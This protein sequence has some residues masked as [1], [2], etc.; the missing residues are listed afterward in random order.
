MNKRLLSGAGLIAV[1]CILLTAFTPGA[2]RKPVYLNTSY[3]FEERA[4]DLVSRMTPEE[5]QSLLG[6]SMAAVPRL[7]VN[8]YNVWGEALHGYASY[9]NPEGGPATSFPNSVAVGA[10]WDPD[11]VQREASAIADEARGFNYPVIN[12]LTYW[13]PVVE[14]MRDPRWGRTG[15]SYGEDPYL[16]AQ[17]AGGFIRGLLGD[18][19]KYLKAVPTGKHFFANNSEFN[20]H[21]SSSDMDS[22]DMREF[23]LAS[24]KKLIEKD[25][26][27]SIMTCYN[28]VNGIP[29]T[30]NKFLVDTIARKTY[31]MKGYVTGDC[32]AVSDI[33]SGHFY[34]KTGPEAAAMGL[35][36]GVDTDCGSVYQTSALDALKLGLISEA[37]IDLALVNMF[38][39]RMRIGEFDPKAKVTYAHIGKE[40]I[41]SPGHVALAEEVAIKTPVLLKNNTVS[42]T[43][44]KALPLK[45]G[46][47]KKIAVL[48]PQADKV[49]LGPYSGQTLPENMITPLSGI[50]DFLKS[51]N[52]T[53]EIVHSAGA[54]TLSSSNLFNIFWFELVKNDGKTV[55]FDANKFTAS[56]K[57]IISSAGMT[58]EKSVKNIRDGGWTSYKDIDV[59]GVAKFNIG[60]TV[61]G[62]GGIIEVRLDSENGRVLAVVEAKAGQGMTSAFMTRTLTGENRIPEASGKQNLFLVYHSPA[63]SRA[64]ADRKAIEMAASADVALVFVGTDD[65]TANE[66][67]DRLDLLLPGNQYELIKAVAEVNPYTVVVMQTLGM[68]EVEQF[69]N[70]PNVAGIIWTGFNGQ[71]QGRAIA[72]ILFGDVNPGG[73]LNA[74]WF[75]SLNDIPEITDYTLRGGP[76]KNGRTYWYFSKDVSYEFGYGL[77]YTTF[78]YGNFGIDKRSI[79][80]NDKIKISVDVTNSGDFDGDEVVQVYVKTPDSPASLQRPAKRLKGFQRIAIPAGQTRTVTIGIDCA[81]LWFWDPLNKKIT[82]DQGRYIFEIGSSS[83]DI[84]GQ[85]EAVMSGSFKPELKT[86]VAECGKVVMKAGST[87]QTSVTAAMTDDS[88]YDIKK[89]NVTYK[90][91]NPSVASVDQNGLVTARN[92]G[93]ATITA[94]V[95]IDGKTVSGSYPLKVMPDLR[96]NRLSLNDKKIPGFNPATR[97]YS[98]LVSSPSSKVPKVATLHTNED[99]AVTIVQAEKIPGT[100]VVTLTDNITSES[101]EYVVSFGTRAISDEF[102]GKTPGRQWSWIRENSAAWNM[103]KTPGWL[104][105]T[106]EKG[107]IQGNTNDAGNILLQ[108]A[109][110]DWTAETVMRFSERLSVPGQKAGIV[111]YQDDDNYVMLVRDNT[112]KGFMGIDEYIELIYEKNGSPYSAANFKL[113]GLPLEGNQVALK[114]VKKGSVYTAYYNIDGKGY[115]LLG[116]TDVTL[117]DVKAGLLACNGSDAGMA[118]NMLALMMGAGGNQGQKTEVKFDYFRILSTGL[119]F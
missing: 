90:S 64:P 1:M 93:T 102:S 101:N 119:N 45:A 110:T 109:N 54:N 27:P 57:G 66:E 48:G 37:E 69:K 42:R 4:A 19:K 92:T 47:I 62:D 115:R 79:T 81:D 71:A 7:G 20:R 68:V 65:R 103:T 112:L 3:S 25:K 80:P 107:D 84:R 23:Y 118:G 85:V 13:S 26:L 56:S 14:A 16:I 76:D 111:A 6:N 89:A 46:E 99:V 60:L 75:K 8:A 41:N 96:L 95:T 67:A 105:F 78:E 33:Q 18:D 88:F 34:V 108:N 22:R 100:A 117:R 10:S 104:E 49:E 29:V 32:G 21:I 50:K 55:R 114:L 70:I 17:I 38:T 44:K 2:T 24:Y 113:T 59:S 74:T 97:S 9:F 77:S 116:S 98:F 35:K 94:S 31:G 51:I 30:A 87:A 83:K 36:A 52:S 43:G 11:L 72:R 63:E 5:K 39:I 28:A 61:P 53:V 40:V 73:K 12:G 15:E 86:V 82:F 58:P 106:L 91:N